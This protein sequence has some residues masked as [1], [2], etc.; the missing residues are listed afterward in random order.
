MICNDIHSLLL[1][2]VIN[3]LYIVGYVTGQIVLIIVYH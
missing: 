3:S 1:K 2:D